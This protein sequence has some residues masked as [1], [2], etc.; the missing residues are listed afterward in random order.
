MDFFYEYFV[1]PMTMSGVQGYNL[2]NTLV[3]IVLLVIACGIIYYLLRNK[4]EF[5]FQFTLSMIPYI[6]FGISMRVIM[7]Q[8]EAGLLVI[9][10]IVKTANPLQLGFWFFTPGIW[11]LTFALVIIGLLLGGVLKKLELRRTIYF[12]LII[13]IIPILFNFYYFNNWAVF[14]ATLALILVVSYGLCYLVNRFTKYKILNDK[15]N[16]FIVLGQ[17]FD[18]IASAI[19]IAFFSFSEQHVFSNMLMEIS[20]ALFASIKLLIALLICWSLDDYLKDQPKKKNI[21]GFIK[22]I[23]A[24]LGLATGLAS[25]FKLGII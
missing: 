7:H 2:I 13:M 23:I 10:G 12:G 19:A 16:F 25:L 8:I 14:L 6:L 21:V 18:G 5:N 15:T 3:F 9:D 24:I 20:P 11:I 4:V 22:I 17:G 1:K